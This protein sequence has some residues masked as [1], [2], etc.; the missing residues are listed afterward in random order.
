MSI[1]IVVANFWDLAFWV[2]VGVCA[3]DLLF[4]RRIR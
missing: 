4:H 3:W 2:I 1:R